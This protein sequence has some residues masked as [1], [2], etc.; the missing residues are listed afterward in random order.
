M[1]TYLN[2]R[3]TVK[4]SRA[5]QEFSYIHQPRLAPGSSDNPAVAAISTFYVINSVHDIT[6][7]YGFTEKAFNFQANNFGKGGAEND[8]VQLT[9][10]AP[11]KTENA[12]F[13]TPRE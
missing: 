2:D 13:M 1:I 5:G 12:W 10:Q 11:E 4:Q 6:Y 7:R 9:V 8:P 3:T